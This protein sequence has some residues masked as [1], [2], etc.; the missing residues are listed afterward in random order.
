M[1]DLPTIKSQLSSKDLF[2]A[3]KRQLAKD[4]EQS[5]FPADL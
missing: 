4:C 2:D 3:F 5:N 1:Q